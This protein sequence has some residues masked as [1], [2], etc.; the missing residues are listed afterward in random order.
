M[1]PQK[2]DKSNADEISTDED[3]NAHFQGEHVYNDISDL[4]SNSTRRL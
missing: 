2:P 1:I 3:V 4:L